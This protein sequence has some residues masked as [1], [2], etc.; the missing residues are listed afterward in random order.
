MDDEGRIVERRGKVVE[1]DFDWIR[2]FA[3]IHSSMLNLD[4]QIE[5]RIGRGRVVAIILRC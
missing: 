1:R 3:F 4:R 2:S 5:G